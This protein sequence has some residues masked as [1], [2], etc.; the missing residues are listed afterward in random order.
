MFTKSQ[1][2]DLMKNEKFDRQMIVPF[3]KLIS[4]IEKA[5]VTMDQDSIVTTLMEI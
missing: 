4:E 1:I 5:I 2:N 3:R